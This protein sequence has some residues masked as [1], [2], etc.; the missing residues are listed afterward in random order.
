MNKKLAIA[1]FSLWSLRGRAGQLV[2]VALAFL[3][4]VGAVQAIGTLHDNASTQT[5]QKIAQSWRTPYDLLIRPQ[6]AVSRL[7][8]S[9]GWIDPQSALE[10]YGGISS[11]QVASIRSLPRVALVAPFAS[12]GWQTLA[13]SVPVEFVAKGIYRVS[14]KWIGPGTG[15]ITENTV[16]RYVDVTDLAHLTTEPTLTSVIVEHLIAKDDVTPVVFFMSVQ[17]TQALIGVPG[18]QRKTISQVLLE[19]IAPAPPVHLSLHVDRLRGDLAVLPACVQ[20]ADCWEAQQVR[21]GTPTYQAGGVQLLRYSRTDYTALPQQI[22]AGQISLQPVGED[23][24]GLLYRVQLPEHVPGNVGSGYPQE[25]PLVPLSWPQRLPGLTNAVRFIPLE[26]ACLINGA[27]CYSGLYVRL[28][29][30]ERYSQA[31]LALLQATSAAIT[32]RTGLHVD[33]LDG[34]SLRTVS[35][36]SSLAST[37]PVAQSSWRVIGVAIQIVHGLDALQETLLVLCSLVCLLAIAAAGVLVGIGR[38]KEALLLQQIGW[39]K[40]DLLFAFALDAL[41]LCLP[42]CLLALTW[43]ILATTLQPTTLPPTIVCALLIIGATLYCCTLISSACLK[44]AKSRRGG[45]GMEKGGGLY[46]RPWWR[47]RTHQLHTR[48]SHAIPIFICSIAMTSATFLIAIECLL[49]T[50]FNQVLVVTVL[51]NQVR[52]ALEVPQLALL[53]LVL[54][55][56][57]LTV[58]LCTMLLLRGRRQELSLLAMVGW[59]RRAVLLR[60]MRDSWWSALVSGE[61]GALLALGVTIVG[62]AVPPVMIVVGLLVCGPLLGVALVSLVTLGPAW[63]ETKRVFVWR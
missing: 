3:L 18:S 27:S 50:S 4:L 44:Q 31:S 54:L 59:E 46:G 47:S 35:I 2:P 36:V 29:G 14:A 7:E 58:G 6:S 8:R 37:D 45:S 17:A 1:N 49:F 52:E 11:Q 28:N 25:E 5:Q 16:V 9:A 13:V 60:V 41:I 20:R 42:G 33:I 34:S 21:Q 62:G 24:Q 10:S 23:M 38:R 43:I 57:L 51:G 12:I 22:G 53:F 48:F 40:N 32:A 19:G 56:A 30:V 39:Q 61:A 55:A 63:Q 26:Q 15:G